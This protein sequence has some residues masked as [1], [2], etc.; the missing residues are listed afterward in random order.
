MLLSRQVK[1]SLTRFEGR[2]VAGS[3]W[4]EWKN[5]TLIDFV[6][7]EVSERGNKVP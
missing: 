1:M 3:H 2:S 6:Y 7:S 5:E 4:L